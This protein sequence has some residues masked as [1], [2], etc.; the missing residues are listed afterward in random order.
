VVVV[1]SVPI[2]L[3][4]SVGLALVGCS[5]AGGDGDGTAASA[6]TSSVPTSSPAASTTAGVSAPTTTT[7][8]A[9]PFAIPE[10]IDAAYVNRVLAALYAVDGDITREILR[11][12]TIG[13]HALSRLGA[14]YAEPQLSLE[15][16]GL[17]TVLE[18]ERSRFRD[19]P[20]DRR[21]DVRSLHKA[22]TGCVVALANLSL[23]E[24]AITPPTLAANEAY[25]IA[26]VPKKPQSDPEELNP[27]PWIIM[28]AEIVKQPGGEDA[29]GAC[30]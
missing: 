15:V 21:F 19:P 25:L 10:V 9:D 16:E 22:G 7:V 26:L 27:T 13:M 5:G 11:T 23:V 29:R 30:G 24:V 6:S 28:D 3:A 14:I 8:G 18:G 2:V 20:G 1:R 12:G 17:P 4:L